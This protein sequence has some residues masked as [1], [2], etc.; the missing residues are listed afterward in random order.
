MHGD[1]DLCSSAALI[2]R[3]YLA[4]FAGNFATKRRRGG[5]GF[6]CDADNHS[7][8]RFSRHRRESIEIFACARDSRSRPDPENALGGPN[9]QNRAK[10]I[11]TRFGIAVNSSCRWSPKSLKFE[12]WREA[13]VTFGIRLGHTS[14][15]VKAR[16]LRVS[17]T[18]RLL[19]AQEP[20]AP[21]PSGVTG[22]LHWP[23]RSPVP[24]WRTRSSKSSTL[25]V[26]MVTPSRHVGHNC[27]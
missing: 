11:R 9:S 19:W 23:H 24:K 7:V 16:I 4:K 26:S 15:T 3:E 20:Q 14:L 17:T 21:S 5:R 13:R 8:S 18:W 27:S 10:P 1:D 2:K 6:K 22:L 12:R 25:G